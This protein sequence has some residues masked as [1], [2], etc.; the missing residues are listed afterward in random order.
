MDKSEFIQ[1]CS[2]TWDLSDV[3]RVFHLG[4]CVDTMEW[5]GKYMM[6]SNFGY[7]K[8]LALFCFTRTRPVSLRFEWC[9]VRSAEF[10]YR[11]PSI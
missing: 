7:S 8:K 1:A 3:E 6:E 10:F 4:A 9:G 5:D 11:K 2:S